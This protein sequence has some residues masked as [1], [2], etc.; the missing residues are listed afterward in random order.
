MSLN[1]NPQTFIKIG[2]GFIAA[3]LVFA[4]IFFYPILFQEAKYLLTEPAKSE[5]VE[6]VLNKEEEG[7][8]AGKER[9]IEPVDTYFGIVIPKINA[10][11]SVVKD[12][13]Y[14]N[15]EEYQK[16]LTRGVAHALGTKLPGQIGNVF[17]FSHSSVNFYEATRYN[18]IFYLLHK[19]EKGDSFYFVYDQELFEYKVTEKKIVDA[20][21]VEYLENL[22]GKKTA[23]LMTCW[24]PG[25]S[26]R[27]LLV[28][29]ELYKF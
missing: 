14:K 24:P 25:T 12:V 15:P 5:R 4:V 23:T 1:F 8:L 2:L 29:S 16:A 26:L 20:S 18:S 10:N 3:S 17:I 6:V 7:K 11:A 9:Q 28:I 21:A 27:R 19:L 13:D 22:N